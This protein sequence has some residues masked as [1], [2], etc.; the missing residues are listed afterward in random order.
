[1]YVVSL[2]H[3][4]LTAAILTPLLSLSAQAQIQDPL[5]PALRP[6]PSSASSAATAPPFVD[7]FPG[8]QQGSIAG[9]LFVPPGA[10]IVTEDLRLTGVDTSAGDNFG[11]DVYLTGDLLAVGAPFDNLIS[12]DAGSAYLFNAVTGD[13]IRKITAPFSFLGDNF[14][15]AVA[16]SGASLFAGAPREDAV[17]TL[18]GILYNFDALTGQLLQ[19]LLPMGSGGSSP[20]GHS[21]GEAVD[22]SSMLLVSGSRGDS[23]LAAGGGSVHVFDPN[24]GSLL[25]KLFPEDPGFADNFGDDVATS[26]ALVLVGSPFDNDVAADSGSAYLFD[27][28]TG[29]QLH[30]LVPA[31]TGSQDL[32]G[33]FVALEGDTAL[34]G[35]PFQDADSSTTDSGAVY[36]YDA[37]SGTLRTRL[38]SPQPGQNFRFGD[39]LAIS[40]EYILVG[41]S[42]GLNS[43]GIRSGSIYVYD[44]STFELRFQLEASDGL[45][46]DALGESISI[47]GR[48]V[49]AG[50]RGS[51]T[52]G[53]L[54][55]TVYLFTLP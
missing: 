16:L 28:I 34:V 49:A 17:T 7:R 35:A 37:I 51:D 24:S 11:F 30:K 54:A 39:G 26:G 3:Y 41:E 38:T 13:Q 33:L 27:G 15:T 52:V 29:Q 12:P 44:R 14:G 45:D 21:L 32:A 20:V 22:A 1:M 47:D 50:A 10:A 36:V 6:L 42:L 18:S 5:A 43:R 55:G 2:P 25:R 19:E 46:V 23:F 9:E 4:A 8:G 48:R 53:D 31:D 40:P